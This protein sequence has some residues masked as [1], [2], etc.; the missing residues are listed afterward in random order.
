MDMKWAR[1]Y[2][3]WAQSLDEPATSELLVKFPELFGCAFTGLIWC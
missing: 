2:Q 3:F 1:V